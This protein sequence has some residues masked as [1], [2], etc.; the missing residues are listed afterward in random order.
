MDIHDN[1]EKMWHETQ[2]VQPGSSDWGFHLEHDM[3][4]VSGFNWVKDE[5]ELIRFLRL[6]PYMLSEGIEPDEETLAAVN[7]VLDQIENGTLGWVAAISLFNQAY[8]GVW[9]VLWWGPLQ[10]LLESEA[11]DPAWVR[12]LFWESREDSE[13]S[14]R[15]IPAE[16]EREF[17][18]W[19]TEWA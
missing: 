3:A 12:E 4:G 9:N 1:A 7:E 14:T 2:G 10:D 5:Q 16:L 15:P 18:T 13:E 6:L 11:E 8:D 19:L 17:A